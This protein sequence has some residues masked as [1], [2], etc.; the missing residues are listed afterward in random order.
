MATDNGSS[1]ISKDERC[2]RESNVSN[3]Y[4]P[5]V[6]NFSTCFTILNPVAKKHLFVT[7]TTIG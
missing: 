5:I 7:M 4:V 1:H 2:F 6:D 3:N